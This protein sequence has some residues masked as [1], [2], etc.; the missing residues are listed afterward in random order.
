MEDDPLI[1]SV[2]FRILSSRLP[3]FCPERDQIRELAKRQNKPGLLLD[4]LNFVS[5]YFF[6]PFNH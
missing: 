5:D 6:G 1:C 4:C 2:V 3:A